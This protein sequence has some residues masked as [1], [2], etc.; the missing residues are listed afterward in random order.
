LI[1]NTLY[2]TINNS[3][4]LNS[5]KRDTKI[6]AKH[7]Y[8]SIVSYEYI[9]FVRETA[10]Y[11]RVRENIVHCSLDTVIIHFSYYFFKLY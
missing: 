4:S 11:V 9:K 10:K 6:N 2:I 8:L 7:S 5:F 3:D 1:K